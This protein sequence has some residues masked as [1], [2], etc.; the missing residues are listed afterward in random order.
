MVEIVGWVVH[1]PDL[2]HHA[3]RTN[4]ACTVNATISANCKVSN[5]NRSA[6]AAYGSTS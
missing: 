3:P 5:P 6:A 2:R 1:H 4:I